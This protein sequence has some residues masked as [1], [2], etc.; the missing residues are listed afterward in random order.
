MI[1]FLIS[2][3]GIILTSGCGNVKVKHEEDSRHR[4]RRASVFVSLLVARK[5]QQSLC[6]VA[7]LGGVGGVQMNPPLELVIVTF[8]VIM[9][10]SP[11]LATTADHTV[12]HLHL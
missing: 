3:L 5:L 9:I 12:S 11:V 2:R 6:P 4:W 1:E 8:A 10:T 7:D